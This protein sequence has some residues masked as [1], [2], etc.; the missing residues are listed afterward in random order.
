MLGREYEKRYRRSGSIAF[1][2]PAELYAVHAGHHQVANYYI[3]L[4]SLHFFKR[5]RATGHRYH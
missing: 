5:L 3:G 2:T 1:K 4:V